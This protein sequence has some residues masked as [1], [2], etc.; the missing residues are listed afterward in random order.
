MKIAHIS[1]THITSGSTFVKEAFEETVDLVNSSDADFVVHTGD[2]TQTGLRDEYELSLSFLKDRL[3][4]P[5]LYIPGNH[6]ARN[7]G[8]ELFEE[9]YGVPN[10]VMKGDD[11]IIVGI[12]S[13]I[14]D[15]NEGR[16]SEKKLNFVKGHLRD[17]RDKT[18]IIALHH[19]VVPIPKT[20]R[21]RNVLYNAGDVLDTFL[22][23]GVDLVLCGHRH[24]QNNY[25]IEDMVVCNAG[26]TSVRKMRAGHPHN[27]NFIDINEKGVEVKTRYLEVPR[28]VV[29]RQ[30]PKRED[31]LF[32]VGERALRLIHISDTHVAESSAFKDDVFKKAVARINTLEPDVVIHTGDITDDG[33][34]ESYLKANKEL[35]TLTAPVLA[36][37]GGRDMRSLG[38]EDF[39]DYIGPV[40]PMW[41]FKDFHIFGINTAQNG[42]SEGYVGRYALKDML[43]A[44]KG[45][46]GFKVVFFH[47]HIVPVPRT[48]EED[49]IQDAGDVLRGLMDVGVSMVLTGSKHKSSCTKIEG[50]LTASANTLSSRDV[51]SR[52]RW[53]FLTIDI[54][55]RG[56][57][58]VKE[59]AVMTGFQRVLGIYNLNH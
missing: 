39:K 50:T 13:T 51:A 36:V 7:V 34:T 4:K 14:P 46:K 59:T 44:L 8:Y 41:G 24:M 54:M 35:K 20:G 58:V 18:K 25:R 26:S 2:I 9:Y 6:D 37:P 17:A 19:H 52:Y 3:N 38:D 56:V 5:A 42:T 21:E 32:F 43:K 16:V 30:G 31:K 12:D 53:S 49:L 11:F 27:F 1:D 40:E 15:L 29:Y 10:P 28:E 45:I 57:V 48:R 23:C 47:H 22:R 33:L 55:P